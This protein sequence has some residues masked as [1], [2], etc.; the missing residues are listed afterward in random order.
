MARCREG[1]RVGGS[2]NTLHRL[3]S[4]K[5]TGFIAEDGRRDLFR[6]LRDPGAMLLKAKGDR[7]VRLENARLA[8]RKGGN[9]C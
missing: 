1:E 9:D 6:S 3:W 2:L 4:W 8:A 5:R 7:R